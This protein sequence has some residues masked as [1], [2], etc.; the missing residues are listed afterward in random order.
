MTERLELYRCTVCGNLVEVVLNGYGQLVCCGQNMVHLEEQTNDD[1]L[2]NEKHVPI[3][4]RTADG[5]F[6]KVGSTPHPMLPEHYITMIEAYS[7]DKRYVKRKYL[8]PGEAPELL[9]KCGCENVVARE[10]C[11]IHGLWTSRENLGS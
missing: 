5:V 1:E 9:I 11:N 4:E 8:Y 2:L 7:P 3:I 6:I 10:Y